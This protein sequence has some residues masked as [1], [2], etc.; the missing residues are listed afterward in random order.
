MTAQPNNE[1]GITPT[2]RK[3][4]GLD[5]VKAYAKLPDVRDRFTDLLGKDD[6]SYYIQTVITVCSNNDKLQECTP[7]SIMIAALRSAALRL[8]VDPLLKQAHL[9]PFSKECTLIVDY[10]GYVQLMDR[11][12]NYRYINVFEVWPGEIVLT[13]RF[14]GVVTIQGTPTSTKKG[15]EIGWCAYFQEKNGRERYLFMDNAEI[16]AHAEFY[17]PGGFHNPKGLW[18]KSPESRRDMRRKTPL[19]LLASKWGKFSPHDASW[20]KGEEVNGLVPQLPPDENLVIENQPRRPTNELLKELGYDVPTPPTQKAEGG[21]VQVDP[22][23]ESTGK[24]G[25]GEQE[26]SEGEKAAGG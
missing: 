21:S 16:D 19:R 8:S 12:G 5:A 1:K 18:Q 4:V 9:V 10:H 13:N 2:Q 17:N 7:K 11:T 23:W 26:F 14:T 20:L 25:K 24:D 6:A 3:A 22:H 15:D